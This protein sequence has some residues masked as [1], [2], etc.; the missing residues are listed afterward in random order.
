[1]RTVDDL[2]AKL[3]TEY[4]SALTSAQFQE[5]AGISSR[6]AYKATKSGLVPF[7]KICVGR[8][9]YYQIKPE[10]AARYMLMRMP[11]S[12]DAPKPDKIRALALLLKT[13]PDVLS[14]ADVCRITG[15]TD[16]SV[17]K[18]ISKGFLKTFRWKRFYRIAKKDLISYMSSDR[19]WRARSDS[20]QRTAA[21]MFIRWYGEQDNRFSTKEVSKENDNKRNDR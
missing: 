3:R 8:I 9:R 4:G 6:T 10:D 19:F 13:E 11:E 2:A 1:M 5:A 18:W 7:T 15:M 17:Q 21:E 14:V 20:L 16:T 12:I